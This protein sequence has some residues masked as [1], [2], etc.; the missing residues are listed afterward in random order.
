M[1]TINDNN[2]D[3]NTNLLNNY[4]LIKS[5][6]TK[7]LKILLKEINIDK[8]K[9]NKD[10][11]QILNY[12]VLKKN[13]NKDKFLNSIK[14]ER[15]LQFDIDS[16]NRHLE[17][18]L[19]NLLKNSAIL[20]LSIDEIAYFTSKRNLLSFTS[21]IY[22]LSQVIRKEIKK[23]K[24]SF[25]RD[26]LFMAD[27][28]FVK[29]NDKLNISKE[30]FT[31]FISELIYLY[32]QIHGKE[33]GTNQTFS[34]KFNPNNY[35]AII[36][37]MAIVKQ[38]KIVDKMIDSLDYTCVK[39]KN[40]FWIKG[41]DLLFEKARVHGFYHTDNQRLN[42][43]MQVKEYYSK[44]LSIAKLSEKIYK[45]TKDSLFE[46]KEKP[47]P[48]YVYKFPIFEE[49]KDIILNESLFLEELML[50]AEIDMEYNVTDLK[51]FKFA[52]KLTIWDLIIIQRF[53]FFYFNQNSIF[54]LSLLEEKQSNL[55]I[56]YNSW[57]KA[58]TRDNLIKMMNFFIDKEKAEAFID[59]FSWTIESNKILDLQYTPLLQ[60]NFD[61]YF[62][63]GI[64]INSN[65][66]RNS[67]FKNQIRPHNGNDF[68]SEFISK[69]LKNKF[70]SVKIEVEF[71]KFNFH[72]DFDV[73]ALI[74]NTLYIFECKNTIN[75]VG[76]HELITTY[77][78]NVIKG[79][80]QLD[81]AREAFSHPEFVSYINNRF[82]WKIDISNLK[83][84]TCVVLKTRM[85]NG[86]TNGIHHVRAFD[87]LLNFIKDGK[88][89][90]TNIKDNKI[91]TLS[92]WRKSILSNEDLYQYLENRK[93]H[94]VLYECMT[95]IENRIK[96]GT[97]T[98]A[99][100]TFEFNVNLFNESISN[101]LRERK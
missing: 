95:P 36:D 82:N 11:L 33:D 87:E 28:D 63:M 32:Y 25:I 31:E 55:T 101:T 50:I 68:I 76:W 34:K 65:L 59:N 39:D 80:S 57:I 10:K 97:Q 27:V 5:K 91:K 74:E 73:L 56:V 42:L 72:G 17:Y 52:E 2:L 29:Y 30:D 62:P 94:K 49:I 77:K 20:E 35:D 60:N 38:F 4:V 61:Y 23:S 99:F 83:I 78:D 70:D 100:E 24:K 18:I 6:N 37:N 85:F 9:K 41:K 48:R 90:I 3:K 54:L 67:L 22:E 13:I 79:F 16:K 14:R 53:L 88:M 15:L 7:D 75:P 51:K 98:I 89:T 21:E 93:F 26:L 19:K 66:F 1:S 96:L 45:A 81:K 43:N 40:I 12:I 44:A 64:L 86:Y 69:E 84:V 46:F 47:I 8:A 92:L 58:L 71:N